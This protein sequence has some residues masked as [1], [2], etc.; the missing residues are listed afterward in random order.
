V[1]L[2]V[3]ERLVGS[4]PRVEADELIRARL[5]ERDERPDEVWFAHALI[6]EVAYGSLLKRRRRELHA[7]AAAAIETLWPDRVEEHLGMLARHHRGA[8]DL[9]TA[10]RCHDLAAERAERLHAG[11]EALEHLTASI[12]LAAELGRSVVDPEVAEPVMTRARVR[13]RTGDAAG[14]RADLEAILATVDAKA[15]PRLAMRAHDELGFVL[16]G[17]AD[18][19]AAVPH[20]EAALATAMEL[21]DA[22]AEVSALSRLSIV[23]ANR[24]DFDTALRHGERALHSAEASGDE[25]LEAAAM[26][27]LKQTALETGDFETLEGLADRLAEIYR[28]NDDLWLLQFAV[29]EVAYADL[30]RMRVERAFAG[31]EEALSINRRIGDVGNEPL[32]VAMLG[33]AHRARGEYDEALALG[34]R[35]FDLAVELGHGEWTA[36]TAAWLGA[37][38]LELGALDEAARILSAGVEAAERAAADLHLVRCFGLHAWTALRSGDG[39][40]AVELADRATAILDRIRVSPPRAYVAGQDAYVGVAHVRLARGEPDAAAELVAPIVEACRDCGWSDGVV[41]GSL[42]LVE[43]A[44]RGGDATAAV[45]AAGSAVAEAVRT[46]LPT[47]WRA[48]RAMAEACLA[49]GDEEGAASHA[50]ETGRAVAQ[51][52]DRIHDRS[53]REAFESAAAGGRFSEGDGRWR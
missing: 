10:R 33:R 39:D 3:L 5:F 36:W 43:V 16:A 24:L 44:L 32:Y 2:P 13:A 47:A 34:R 18:Y 52:R 1:A 41:E 50:T 23:H 21:G 7:S 29:F 11:E 46:G 19:R 22:A 8:G 26:D 30:A 15:E 35:A 53:I 45:E 12:D 6:Q 28:R 49:V 48:H 25:R 31:L 38:L 42:V 51:M 17:A 27:A 20:L 9:E 40:L 14:A 4:D 37:T